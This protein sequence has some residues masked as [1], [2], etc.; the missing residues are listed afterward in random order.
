[1]MPSP[2]LAGERVEVDSPAGR[3]SMYVAGA[4]P[5]LLLI[6]SVNAVATAAE[7]R[8]LH[9]HYRSTRTVYSLDLPGFGF[10]ERS[11]RVYSP[12]LMTD[13]IKAAAGR[14]LER[15][16][17]AAIDALALSLSAEFLA[18]AAAEI[19]HWFR[20]LAL[21]SPTGFRGTKPRRAPPGTTRAVPG[22]LRI[23]RGPRNA[24]GAALF[25]GLTRP[26]VIRYF[27]RRTWGSTRIDDVLWHY[28]IETAKVPGAQFAPLYF[29]SGALFS[30]D[31]LDVYERLSMPVWMCHG[32]RGDFTDYRLTSLLT[33]RT[34]W[35][36]SVFQ[37]GA[38]PHFEVLPEFCR[39][40]AGLLDGAEHLLQ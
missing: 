26:K 32:V 17:A 39:D 1:M 40:Y 35:R 13:A 14:I 12:R 28:D 2:A 3:L 37:T 36:F 30:A 6:H 15:G 24:W 8:P 5:P 38:L 19:P 33:G 25:R 10:S 31:I 7:V 18:R 11:D 22:L 21:V 16:G 34:N 9:D 23:L 29:L 27:L 4:G 20:S